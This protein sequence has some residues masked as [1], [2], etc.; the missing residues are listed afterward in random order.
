MPKKSLGGKPVTETEPMSPGLL[1]WYASG[2]GFPAGQSLTAQKHQ[3]SYEADGTEKRMPEGGEGHGRQVS[4]Q[5]SSK[6]GTGRPNPKD[7]HS[8]F[9][10]DSKPT[11][12]GKQKVGQSSSRKA[13]TN[14]TRKSSVKNPYQQKKQG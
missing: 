13:T 10:K 4:Q 6:G 1:A 8:K 9:E 5:I 12:P 11:S 14:R 3:T 2:G 7:L